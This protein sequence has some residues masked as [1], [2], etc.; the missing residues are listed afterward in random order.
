MERS[1]DPSMLTRKR[2]KTVSRLC[3]QP[4]SLLDFLT[5]F[6]RKEESQILL[7]LPESIHPVRRA[8]LAYS[9]LG[10]VDDFVEY[11]EQ[12][13]FG[14]TKVVDNSKEGKV[15]RASYLSSLT[16]DDVTLAN[17]S[18]FFSKLFP[19]LCA[20]V[21][22]FSAIEAVLDHGNTD[23]N[24]DLPVRGK[25]GP[26]SKTN[27]VEASEAYEKS[28]MAELGSLYRSRAKSASYVD[29]VRSSSLLG[30][31]LASLRLVHPS[32]SIRRNDKDLIVVD[33]DDLKIA[34]RIAGD[35][36]LRATKVIVQDDR[37]IPMLVSNEYSRKGSSGKKT[38]GIPDPEDLDLPFGL[39]NMKQIP[40]KSSDVSMVRSE[41]AFT[42]SQSV[43]EVVRALHARC[44][45]CAVYAFSLEEI[46]TKFPAKKGSASAAYVID[47]IEHCINFAAIGLKDSDHLVNEGSVDKAVQVMAN[48]SALQ[49]CLPRLYGTM[50]R[51]MCHV[52]LV[53]ADEIEDTFSY[54]EKSLKASDSAC[55]TQVGSTY[56]LVYEICR[57]KID[58]HI[59]YALENFNWV[60]KSARD[61]PNAYCE[62]L[63]GYL[64]TVFA[65]LGPMDEASRNGLHFSC[66][67]HVSERLVKLFA[68]KPGD[69]AAMDPS[70]IP[71]ISRIDAF[72]IKNLATDCDEL[73]KFADS[74]GIPALR[75]CFNELRV[76]T[77]VML[78]KELPSLVL[79][80]NSAIRRRKYPILSMDKVANILEKYVGTG[81]GDKLMGGAGRKAEILFIEKKEVQQLIKIV[82]S[83]VI[84]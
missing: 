13:R 47:S 58:S 46:G 6:A 7:S 80:E 23:Q 22:G 2:S 5:F 49:Y 62:G 63:I 51:G 55:D 18:V 1:L 83:Q 56:S 20:S 41:E 79:P 28:L 29:L 81:L 52:G 53:R 36:M 37:K 50:V 19:V 12:N 14:E 3:C 66:L 68:D 65:S 59:N 10:K 64:Q 71:P 39:A 73:E 42:F 21:V 76:L 4:F 38:T 16:G 75:D 45:A 67:G 48:I 82:R 33:S 78:D 35:E 31:M 57:N 61:M 84:S 24:G 17:S 74:T 44:I 72:G 9:L 69:T 70:S 25:G 26:S 40:S 11:Y 34:M 15:E 32:S 54:A 60:A 30:S 27:F 43:P 77:S 8:E